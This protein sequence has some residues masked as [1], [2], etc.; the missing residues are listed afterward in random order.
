MPTQRINIPGRGDVEAEEVRISSAHEHW[1]EYLLEDG[2]TLRLKIVLSDVHR[3]PDVFDDEGDPL[4][5]ARSTNV[6]DVSVPESLRR[7][8]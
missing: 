5:V 4:Y 8:D 6:M 2:T 7:K 1:N 3:V